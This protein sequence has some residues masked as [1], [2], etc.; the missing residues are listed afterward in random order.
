MAVYALA[1]PAAVESL[2]VTVKMYETPV[3][4][5]ETTT[6]WVPVSNGFVW[7]SEPV[8]PAVIPALAMAVP[9]VVEPDT[10]TVNVNVLATV[11]TVLT[12]TVATTV[13]VVPVTAAGDVIVDK[14][15]GGTPVYE[16]VPVAEL[17]A[18]GTVTTTNESLAVR[19]PA[20]VELA[21]ETV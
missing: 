15:C 17:A 5:P 19:V 1:V 6:P 3:V 9:A 11:L 7:A 4:I 18:T 10:P 20:V 2:G 16:P 8:G 14:T 12:V 13:L 21:A